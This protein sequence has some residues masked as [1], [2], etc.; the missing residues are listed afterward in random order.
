MVAEQ[1]SD[2]LDANEHTNTDRKAIS[3]ESNSSSCGDPNKTSTQLGMLTEVSGD[4]EQDDEAGSTEEGDL[5]ND[6]NSGEDAVDCNDSKNDSLTVD[7]A[8]DGMTVINNYFKSKNALCGRCF[9]SNWKIRD[10]KHITD[11]DITDHVVCGPWLGRIEHVY[12]NVI[13][14]LD[15]DSVCKVMAAN[16]LVL[17]PVEISCCSYY[18]RQRVRANHSSRLKNSQWLSGSWKADQLEGIVTNITVGPVT[19]R[20]IASADQE[21]FLKTAIIKEPSPENLKFYLK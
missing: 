9:L 11:F 2:V 20:W 3:E 1:Q 8:R 14:Q 18:P 4:S 13:I 17:T 16:T 12:E 7:Q 21:P 5:E 6:K 19:I 10:L 15:D